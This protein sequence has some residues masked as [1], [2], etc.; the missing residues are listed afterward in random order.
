MVHGICWEES[1]LL[2]WAER[3][4]R[5]HLYLEVLLPESHPE[6]RDYNRHHVHGCYRLATLVWGPGSKRHGLPVEEREPVWNPALGEFRDVA[7]I[8]AVNVD[9]DRFSLL[10]DDLEVV[11]RGA[12]VELSF[13]EHDDSQAFAETHQARRQGVADLDGDGVGVHHRERDEEAA[14]VEAD[15]ECASP[16]GIDSPNTEGPGMFDVPIADMYESLVH[17]M[18][19]TPSVFELV[20]R[21]PHRKVVDGRVW[22]CRTRFYRPE[23]R[24]IAEVLP[25]VEFPYPRYGS[26]PPIVIQNASFEFPEQGEWTWLRLYFGSPF[27]ELRIRFERMDREFLVIRAEECGGDWIYRLPDGRRADFDNPFGDWLK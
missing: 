1:Y 25:N 8:D 24:S 6:Y 22:V 12:T 5:L 19:L 10:A 17:G 18:S 4:G 2:G 14:G 16:I 23:V 27:E 26:E 21:E 13:A 20:F 9:A 3:D 11:V 7:E 15:L